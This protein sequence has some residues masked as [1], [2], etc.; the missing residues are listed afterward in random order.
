M[1]LAQ[2][3]A[4]GNLFCITRVEPWGSAIRYLIIL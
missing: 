2:Y 3:L 4:K 1:E